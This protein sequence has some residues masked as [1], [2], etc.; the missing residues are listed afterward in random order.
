MIK[1]IDDV[2]WKA[3]FSF[4]PNTYHQLQHQVDV[5]MQD[6]FLGFK[7]WRHVRKCYCKTYEYG[8]DETLNYYIQVEMDRLT[9]KRR[10]AEEH[11]QFAH[12]IRRNWLI[13]LLFP[14]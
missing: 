12:N 5:W 7:Y 11:G 3:K 1:T 14:R 2:T 4:D 10:I 13:E 6:T 8:K 9:G